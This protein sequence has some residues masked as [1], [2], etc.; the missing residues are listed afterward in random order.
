MKFTFDGKVYLIEFQRKKRVYTR[1]DY[2]TGLDIPYESTHPYT[3]ATLFETDATKPFDKKLFRTATVGCW[4][5]DQFSTEKGRVRALRL[6]TIT[7]P[8][9]MKT[10][11]WKAYHERRSVES[12]RTLPN[13]D[14]PTSVVD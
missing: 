5:G 12:G 13:P 7:L 6:I 2:D 4:H 8:K 1:F 9:A 3:T 11:M 10:A 14:M